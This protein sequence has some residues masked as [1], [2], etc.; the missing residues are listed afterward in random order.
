[1]SGNTVF[2]SYSRRNLENVWLRAFVDALR[3]RNVSAW[4]D[5]GSVNPGENWAAA[6]ARALRESDTII[7]VLSGEAF[8]SPN[9]YFDLG[10]AL[11]SNKRLIVV[12]DRSPATSLPIEVQKARWIALQEPE[13][14]AREVAEAIGVSD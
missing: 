13:E 9:L 2:I 5:A 10:V 3:D 11:G 12:T 6:A 14:T 8:E 1:M 7:A 4:L